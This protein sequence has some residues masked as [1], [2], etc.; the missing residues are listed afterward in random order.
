MHCKDICNVRHLH[1]LQNCNPYRLRWHPSVEKQNGENVHIHVCVVL[2]IYVNT[3]HTQTAWVVLG[4]DAHDRNK[5]HYC[6]SSTVEILTQSRCE[7]SCGGTDSSGLTAPILVD[8][9][10]L[11]HYLH[12][13]GRLSVSCCFH[14]HCLYFLNDIKKLINHRF[15]R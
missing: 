14:R 7:M 5:F 11:C 8:N 13:F 15:Y 6:F 2:H 1:V 9:F 10:A 4:E 3:K 12:S